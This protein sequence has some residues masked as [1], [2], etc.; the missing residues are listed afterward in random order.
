MNWCT[1]ARIRRSWWLLEFGGRWPI[2]V[3]NDATAVIE[4][5]R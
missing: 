4:L 5:Y 1:R 2:G 3:T